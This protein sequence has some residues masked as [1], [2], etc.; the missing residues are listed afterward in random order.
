MNSTL[1][2]GIIALIIGFGGGYLVADNTAPATSHVMPDG[3][4][5]A[6]AMAGMTSEL[7]G[8]TGDDFD[9][10]FIQEMI[11]HHEGAVAMALQALQQ[12]KH[13]EIKAMAQDIIDAQTREITTM[14]EWLWSWYS[15]QQ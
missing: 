9:K 12:A 11:V 8:K 7:E 13:S 4:S 5:M 2:T 14:R 1:I 6:D 10:A 15:I 3:S